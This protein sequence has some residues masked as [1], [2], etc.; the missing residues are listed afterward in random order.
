MKTEDEIRTIRSN[1]ASQLTQA[2]Q[3]QRR[4]AEDVP[5]LRGAI[6]ALDGV[7]T[8]TEATAPTGEPTAAA[9]SLNGKDQAPA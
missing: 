3:L 9:E 5:M 1:L 8:P 6:Q 7:L 2:E 4:L